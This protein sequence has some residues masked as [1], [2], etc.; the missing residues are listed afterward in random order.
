M[1]QKFNIWTT[2]YGDEIPLNKIEDSHVN[3]IINYLQRLNYDNSINEVTVSEW[4]EVMQKE[5]ISRACYEI[6]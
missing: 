2:G 1:E 3:N 6:Y 4:L 5:K